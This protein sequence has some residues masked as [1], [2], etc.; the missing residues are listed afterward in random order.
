MSSDSLTILRLV[1]AAI[2]GALFAFGAF[3]LVEYLYRRPKRMKER[4]RDLIARAER[5]ELAEQE[6]RSLS[7]D[8]SSRELREQIDRIHVALAK[9]TKSPKFVMNVSF[10]ALMVLLAI[11]SLL[12]LLFPSW[13][14]FT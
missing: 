14:P 13:L 7:G 12:N 1:L 9:R 4:L 2:N 6:G 5:T 3:L 10:G 8:K 11:L